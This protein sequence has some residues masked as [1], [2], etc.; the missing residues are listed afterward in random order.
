MKLLGWIR[1]EAGRQ[2]ALAAR[3][4]SADIGTKRPIGPPP[5]GAYC[6]R[7]IAAETYLEH[8]ILGRH[9]GHGPLKGPILGA[10]FAAYANP[11]FS[12]VQEEAQLLFAEADV[13]RPNLPGDCHP[14]MS[15]HCSSR[16]TSFVCRR[17]P[18]PRDKLAASLDVARS[19]AL[20]PG[21]STPQTGRRVRGACEPDRLSG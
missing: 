21:R 7:L 16:L 10:Q 4:A 15:R 3:A 13:A 5:G 20:R 2:A 19:R 9:I 8:R 11:L 6:C 18:T 14:L 12:S 17:S 1:V